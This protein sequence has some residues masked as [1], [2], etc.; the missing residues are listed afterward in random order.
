MNKEIMSILVNNNPGVL[1]RISSLFGRRGYNI[2][3][4]TVSATDNPSTSRITATVVGSPATITQIMNQVN[5]LEETQDVFLVAPEESVQ[6]ELLLIKIATTAQN[7]SSLK[8]TAEIFNAHIV[9]LSAS[10][11]IIEVTGKPA[12]INRFL[13][14]MNNYTICEMCRTGVTALMRGNAPTLVVSA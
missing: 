4:L 8:E 9:D 2:E 3:S 10:S 7:I 12:K 11:L 1:A 13:T 5:K 14:L 6:R